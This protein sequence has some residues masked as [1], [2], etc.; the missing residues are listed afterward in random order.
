MVSRANQVNPDLGPRF[1]PAI[2][3]LTRPK[4][5]YASSDADGA[6]SAFIADDLGPFI[7]LY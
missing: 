2:P 5:T 1:F 3:D 6:K 7:S 4:V